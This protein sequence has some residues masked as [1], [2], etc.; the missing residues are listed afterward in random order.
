MH[1]VRNAYC[2]L[3]GKPE[4]K[5]PPRR[6]NFICQNNIRMYLGEMVVRCGLDASCSG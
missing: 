3:I 1:E 4:K 6:P 2:I 5:R